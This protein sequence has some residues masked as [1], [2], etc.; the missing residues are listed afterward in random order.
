[1]RK[2]KKIIKTKHQRKNKCNCPQ[3]K[4]IE[5]KKK[6]LKTLPTSSRGLQKLYH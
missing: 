5:K 1:M 4:S 2:N 6:K 3:I